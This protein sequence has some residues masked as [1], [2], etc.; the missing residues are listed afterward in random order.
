MNNR[1]WNDPP[2]QRLELKLKE[3][4]QNQQKAIEARTRELEK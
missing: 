4:Q 1:N 2:Q 3:T